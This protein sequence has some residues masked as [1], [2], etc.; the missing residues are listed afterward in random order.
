MITSQEQKQRLSES[1]I[2]SLSILRMSHAE[3][4][5]YIN[6][7]ATENP[8]FVFR[9]ESNCLLPHPLSEGVNPEKDETDPYWSAIYED[10]LYEYVKKQLFQTDLNKEELTVALYIASCLDKNGYLSETLKEISA[11]L[12]CPVVTAEKALT[13]VRSL[14]PPG[15]GACDLADCLCL[16]LSRLGAPA[17]VKRIVGKHLKAVSERKYAAIS[18]AEK[19]PVSIIKEAC[20]IIAGLEPRPARS[21]NS[22]RYTEFVYPDAIINTD[23]NRISI[24]PV[25]NGLDISGDTF[26]LDLYSQTND[27]QTA[28]F[29]KPKYKQYL[30][31]CNAVNGREATFLLCMNAIIDR[32]ASYFLYRDCR[33][34]PMT[35]QNVADDLSLHVSTVSRAIQN[36]YVEFK[37]KVF[38]VS[39]LFSSKASAVN[40]FDRTTSET[41]KMYI[42]NCICAED[43]LNPLSDQAICD[44]LKKNYCDISRRAVTKYRNEMEIPERKYR[45][46]I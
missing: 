42:R 32:Q 1:Q 46:K 43:P 31:V 20:R 3:L 39:S 14:D 4:V 2:L 7:M 5:S 36:K 26:Y 11:A 23:G 29:L 38:S 27:P 33:L 19:L 8:F 41:A 10:T 12:C 34:N 9:P 18:Q 24:T 6:S 13:A 17:Y 16:Q 22:N 35:L 28:S 40:P 45:K 21:F 15:I 25:R 44:Y 37:G 30:T